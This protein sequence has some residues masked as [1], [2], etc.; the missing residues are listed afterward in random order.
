MALVSFDARSPSESMAR[1][2]SRGSSAGHSPD[3]EDIAPIASC[4]T[5]SAAI[6]LRAASSYCGVGAISSH[7]MSWFASS[8]RSASGTRSRYS[9]TCGRR[10][11]FQ[12]SMNSLSAR[13]V[14]TMAEHLLQ[15]LH[16]ART[17]LVDVV[18]AGVQLRRDLRHV[19]ALERQLQDLAHVVRQ[20]LERRAHSVGRLLALLLA[21]HFAEAAVAG[22]LRL[23]AAES[24][25]L[26]G[27]L[28]ERTGLVLLVGGDA[29]QR[30]AAGEVHGGPECRAQPGERFP[31]QGVEHFFSR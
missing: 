25:V 9:S 23:V 19:E 6:A 21:L 5:G 20:L 11:A 29:P 14:E 18:V 2:R 12:S 10:P 1:D 22:E 31:P 13:S 28:V 16:A 26:A 27:G 15:L 8:A 3:S 17:Q 7:V 4:T 24:R 30:V